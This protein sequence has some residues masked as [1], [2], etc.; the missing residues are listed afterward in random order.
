MTGGAEHPPV[1]VIVI[2]AGVA[3]LAAAGALVEAGQRVLVLEARDRPGGRVLTDYGL[4]REMPRELG[5]QMIHG[6]T[7]VTHAWLAREGLTA[8]HYPTVR[9]SRIVI[10][11]RVARYPWLFLPFHPVMG[12]RAAWASVFGIPRD[13][14][15]FDGPDCSLEE[16]LAERS[17]PAAARPIVVLLHAHVYATNPDAIGVRGQAEEDVLLTEAHGFHNFLVNEGYSALVERLAT[18]LGDRIVLNAPVRDVRTGEEG[19]AVHVVGDAGTPNVEYTARAVV[20][21]V[22]LSLLKDETIRFDPPLPA[23]KRAA[24][25]RV[26]FGHAYALH[27][28]VRGGQHRRKLGDFAMVYGGTASSFYRPQVGLRRSGEQLVAFTVGR[29]AERRGR[30]S[31]EDM[32]R[33]TVEEWDALLPDDARLGPIDGS[34]VHRWSTDPWTRGAYSFLPPGSTLGDRRALAAPVDGRLFFA[35]EATDVEGH[36][37]TVAGA[38]ATG[39]RAAKEVLALPSR[40]THTATALK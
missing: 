22:P 20:V 30:L 5:A 15:A 33:A 11:R 8:R 4:G 17:V 3:G 26:A 10:G 37:A 2:G 25:G 35:G 7:V 13:L 24:I 1:D 6:S 23:A 9:R 14:L 38:I 40:T 21:T 16:F 18:R 34:R 39:L 19:V 32:V 27:L 12:T 29:E 31:D 36:A 28:T